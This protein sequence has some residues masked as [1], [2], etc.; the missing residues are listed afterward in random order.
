[1]IRSGI[2]IREI[3][4]ADFARV[5]A[6]ILRVTRQDLGLEYRPEW[7]WDIDNLQSVYVDN[8]RQALFVAVDDA[9]GEI[10]GTRRW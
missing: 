3:E 7:H 6:H 4:P 10:I 9:A 8:P 5:R 2:S 1:V